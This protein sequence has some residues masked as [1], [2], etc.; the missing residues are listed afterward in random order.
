VRL[1]AGQSLQVPRRVFHRFWAE[2]GPV[3]AGEVS[4]V[5]DDERDNRFLETSERY[6]GVDEDAPAR[7]LLVSEYPAL[8]AA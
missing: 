2:G 1:V 8:L 6:P 7:Y 3:L 4:T 5:N